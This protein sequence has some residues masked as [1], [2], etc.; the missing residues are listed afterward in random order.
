MEIR[1]KKDQLYR[2]LR[3]AI[4]EGTY[5]PGTK[6]PKEVEFAAQLGVAPV[7]LRSALKLLEEERLIT[8]L[9]SRGTFVNEHPAP[10]AVPENLPAR[11]R[12][13]LLF[14]A[15]DEKEGLE[16]NI[17]NRNLALGISGQCSLAKLEM[18]VEYASPGGLEQ[19]SRRYERGEFAA[20]VWDRLAAPPEAA[21]IRALAAAG[22]PQV[23]VN[24]TCEGVP[25]VTCDY[26][27]AIRQAV[28]SLQAIGHRNIA[29]IDAGSHEPVFLE[30]AE[31]FQQELRK[32]GV[33]QP[34][35]YF[36]SF[37][38]VEWKD[39]Y[40]HVEK[41]M[42]RLPEATAVIVMAFYMRHFTEYLRN[43]GTIVPGELSVIQWGERYGFER[44][45]PTPYSILT[46][47]RMEIGRA[48]IGL[49]RRMLDGE[50]CAN[51]RIKIG[52]EL[53][54]R[55]GCTQPPQLDT[56]TSGVLR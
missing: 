54:L 19:L 25:S 1:F 15:V 47:S 9:R 24:R 6:L 40:S 28:R 23:T 38:G 17:F 21:A 16:Y 43:S 44:S 27:A 46:E 45:S 31:V 33:D 18:A 5:P 56:L 37:D 10:P 8:R 50:P 11:N 39:F 48:A 4:R 52:G 35:R 29:L 7:T 14:P 3:E 26:P 42:R 12:V 49:I 13:L 36:I 2:Q 55:N 34:E 32:G 51:E 41:N 30:R 53:I 22:I 20:V